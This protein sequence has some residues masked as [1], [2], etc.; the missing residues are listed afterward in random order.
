MAVPATAGIVVSL[1]RQAN[2]PPYTISMVKLTEPVPQP[3]DPVGRPRK[4]LTALLDAQSA[5]LLRGD[6]A[7]W[8]AAV[9]PSNAALTGEF[10]RMFTNLR[11]M[12]VTSWQPAVTSLVR[13][14]GGPSGTAEIR[15]GFCFANPTCPTQADRQGSRRAVLRADVTWAVRNGT[16]VMTSF[17]GTGYDGKPSY[18]W[19]TDP[20]TAAASSRVVVA[21][22]A[23]L[24]GRVSST[25][26]IANR[27][28]SFV[29]AYSLGEQP[30]TSY[31]IYLAGPEEWSRWYRGSTNDYVGYALPTSK[32]TWDIVLRIAGIESS[33]LEAMIRHEM[34]H[35][36][37]IGSGGSSKEN[38]WLSEGLAEYIAY[39]DLPASRYIGLPAASYYLQE[40]KWDGHLN[41]T[42]NGG[43]DG[44]SEYAMASFAVRT[45]IDHYGKDRVLDLFKQVV[46]N[47]ASLDTAS[48]RAFGAG[49]F[50]VD[51]ACSA[52]LRRAVQ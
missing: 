13:E 9:D 1:V 36:V 6:Q 47:G 14:S 16:V 37:T 15:F 30:P 34:A 32:A 4:T 29:D 38:R 51:A 22:P 28:A 24:A 17:H 23:A 40:K 42:M 44:Y 33:D 12:G 43:E 39:S 46:L 20:L 45:L 27:A 11:A 52:D 19:Q 49:W 21:A 3:G 2:R 8:L 26:A 18:P 31:T 50:D 25:L 5:A 10:T 7:G 48:K 41:I 35:V